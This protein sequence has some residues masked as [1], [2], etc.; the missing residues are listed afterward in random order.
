[1][2]MVFPTSPTVGQVFTSGGRS[3]VWNGS[4]WDAPSAA[5]VLQVPIGLELVKT[6]TIGTTVATV[7]V[8]GAFS[9]TFDEYLITITGGV[10]PDGGANIGLQLGATTSGYAFAGFRATLNAASLTGEGSANQ[11]NFPRVA[12]TGTDGYSSQTRIS[13]PFNS[14]PTFIFAQTTPSSS[15]DSMSYLHGVLNNST[16]YTDF[17]LILNFGSLTGGTINVYGYRKTF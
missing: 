10:N 4:A 12:R 9:A 16:S 2:A 8:T 1:M 17:T 7:T 5:N 11:P 3:W 14:A 6:Q 13:Q 15:S